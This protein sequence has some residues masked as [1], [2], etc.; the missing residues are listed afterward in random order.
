MNGSTSASSHSNEQAILQR[1]V[2]I[3]IRLSLLAVVVVW[4]VIIF[5]PFFIPSLWAVIIAVALFPVYRK[6]KKLVGGK[7]GLA[8]TLFVLVA[9][10]ILIV[11]TVEFTASIVDSTHTITQQ[12]QEGTLSV[13]PPRESVRTWPLIGER[14]YEAWLLTSENLQASLERFAPQLRALASRAIGVL[15]GLG[16]GILQ[17][18]VAIIIAGVML[19]YA[20]GAVKAANNLFTRLAGDRGE[21]LVTITAATIRSVAQGVLGVAIIQALLGGIGLVFA[22]VPGAGIW[23]LLILILAVAQLPPLLILGPIII[24]V[25]SANESTAVAVI[26]TIWSLIVSISDSFLKPM[27]LGRGVDI[28]MPVI[29]I[30]AIGG[31]IASGIIGLFVGA[32]VLAIGYRLFIGWMTAG[33]DPA[34]AISRPGIPKPD[35]A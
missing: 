35:T 14:L 20:G 29:L 11:P 4:C 8:G 22:D 5:R 2:E 34:E 30:G 9:L 18:V 26:F 33:R 19:A 23:A 32:V 7:D 27:F 6:L 1:A 28:P 31:M 15:T 10:A 3:S 13:P 12:V 16:A 17:S 24:Y 21:D 25:F